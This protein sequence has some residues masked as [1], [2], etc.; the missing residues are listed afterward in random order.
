MPMRLAAVLMVRAKVHVEQ[1]KSGRQ[2]LLLLRFHIRLS[3]G[4]SPGE[5]CLQAVNGKKIEGISDMRDIQSCYVY[6]LWALLYH[7]LLPTPYKKTQLQS[8]FAS[9]TSFL[10]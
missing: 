9:S 4:S 7:R 3:Y 2:R 8:N 10:G 5:D 6:C 1:V